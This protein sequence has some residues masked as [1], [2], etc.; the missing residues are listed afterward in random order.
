MPVFEYFND[1]CQRVGHDVISIHYGCFVWSSINIPSNGGILDIGSQ[2]C[3]VEVYVLMFG[4][5]DQSSR[6]PRLGNDISLPDSARNSV[7]AH[8]P[9]ERSVVVGSK[10]T[11]NP[12]GVSSGSVALLVAA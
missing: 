1:A 10:D 12:I 8:S 3:S 2:D 11:L 7:A 9:D 6:W 4:M 5:T